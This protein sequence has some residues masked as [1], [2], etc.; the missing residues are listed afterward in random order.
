MNAAQP[1]RLYS[2]YNLQSCFV[3][4]RSAIQLPLATGGFVDKSRGGWSL[5][6]LNDRV[7]F[8]RGSLP[9]YQVSL[10]GIEGLVCSTRP[11]APGGWITVWID[12]DSSPYDATSRTLPAW[13]NVPPGEVKPVGSSPT[14]M[15]LVEP[16]TNQASGDQASQN[17]PPQTESSDGEKPKLRLL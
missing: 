7:R 5:F 8:F 6:N 2:R 10:E 12:W 13:I 17:E 11:D 9:E 16:S 15:K 3:R 14:E 1:L 4:M